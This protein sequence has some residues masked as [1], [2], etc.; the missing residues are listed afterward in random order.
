VSI[1]PQ[2]SAVVK[3]LRILYNYHMTIKMVRHLLAVALLSGLAVVCGAAPLDVTQKKYVVLL[4][5]FAGV[6][7]SSENIRALESAPSVKIAAIER[8]VAG[9]GLLEHGKEVKAL[10][11]AGRI[12]PAVSLVDEP[13]LPLIYEFSTSTAT[14]VKFSWPDDV[15]DIVAR[16]QERVMQSWPKTPAGLVLRSEAFDSE[17]LPIL[18]ALG[19]SWVALGSPLYDARSSSSNYFCNGFSVLSYKTVGSPEEIGEYM[20]KTA[21]PGLSVFMLTGASGLTPAKAIAL[22]AA[23]K[24]AEV[25]LPSAI[26]NGVLKELE[27]SNRVRTVNSY[28]TARQDLWKKIA[29]A[30][31][32]VE[33]YKNSGNAQLKTL[34]AARS[35]LYH[36][37]AS[38][39]ISSLSQSDAQKD[40]Q[41][42]QAGLFNVYQLLGKR[43]PQEPQNGTALSSE[44]FNSGTLGQYLV[45]CSSCNF[46]YH[47]P[48]VVEGGPAI[49]SFTMQMNDS[50]IICT[51]ALAGTALP[52]EAYVDVYMDLNNKRGAGATLML[53]PMKEGYLNPEDAWE[54]ALQISRSQA[55]L[56]RAGRF[57]NSIVATIKTLKPFEVSIARAVLRGNAMR[58]GYQAVL[59][60]PSVLQKGFFDISD[61]LV[62]DSAQRARVLKN[63]PTYLP[64][65]RVNK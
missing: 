59:V 27:A 21:A 7:I 37:Y 45:E 16:D 50:E 56:Y 38:P 41:E 65:A 13:V 31:I 34:E 62:K 9:K 25:V 48:P 55:V 42:F 54:F 15:A 17:M 6:S 46:T 29:A 23:L 4:A 30:R 1:I 32:E 40:E 35:E 57:E 12:E 36:L 11:K 47:N 18:K 14:D 20:R 8:A 61:F 3:K 5:D 10:V 58:W 64:A 28:Y 52:A 2:S 43:Q 63:K 44:L 19:L 39:L 26:P 60:T 33:N 51:V 22:A 49:E 53:P 24:G